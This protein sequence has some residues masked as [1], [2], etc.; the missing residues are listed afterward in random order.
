M[1]R[2]GREV[3]IKASLETGAAQGQSP[4]VKEL[5]NA[6]KQAQEA[7]KVM[8]S[9]P[10]GIVPTTRGMGGGAGNPNQTF[11]GMNASGP[12]GSMMRGMVLGASVHTVGKAASGTIGALVHGGQPGDG[13]FGP[14]EW[15]TDML[16]A[17]DAREAAERRRLM[18]HESKLYREDA[19]F[20]AKLQ[21]K[22]ML[23]AVDRMAMSIQATPF[24]QHR[25]LGADAA[26]LKGRLSE[27]QKRFGGMAQDWNRAFGGKTLKG[28]GAPFK[29]VNAMKFNPGLM[30]A[31]TMSNDMISALERQKELLN[32]LK[33]IEEQRLQLAKSMAQE[34]RGE[35]IQFGSLSPDQRREAM[36]PVAD[37]IKAGQGGM[38]D[39]QQRALAMQIP[40]LRRKLEEQ[41]GELAIKDGSYDKLVKKVGTP[42]EISRWQK[43]LDTATVQAKGV[44]TLNFLVNID[45][46][47]LAQQFADQ[48]RAIVKGITVITH[49]QMQVAKNKEAAERLFK[50]NGGVP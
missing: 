42:D 32:Q 40:L 17:R 19:L 4:L 22:V 29:F 6:K 43:T 46:Q 41:L 38:L 7:K 31:M 8:A 37:A 2:I 48:V 27:E 49:Q 26:N 14:L 36:G 12:L 25:A 28:G 15:M 30:D 18:E 47:L 1:S 24:D 16:T 21:E 11:F 45:Q 10:Q 13:S 33:S 50:M 34:L 35:L 20:A 9:L 39:D 3:V 23:Q 5:D 44:P